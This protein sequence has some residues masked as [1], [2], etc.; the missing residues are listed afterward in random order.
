MSSR[1]GRSTTKVPPSSPDSSVDQAVIEAINHH[2]AGRIDQAEKLYRTILASPP[3]MLSR[4][5]VSACFA[6]R[7]AECRRPLTAYRHAIAA[8]PDFADAYINL[9]TRC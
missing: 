2:H 3:V 8:R 9:G 5:M 7:K 4:V 6:P 1:P